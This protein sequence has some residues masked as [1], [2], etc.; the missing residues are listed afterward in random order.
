MAPTSRFEVP[1]VPFNEGGWGPCTLP[2]HLKDVPYAPYGKN[3]RIGRVADWTSSG[4]YGNNKFDKRRDQNRNNRNNDG[5]NSDQQVANSVFGFFETDKEEDFRLVD[6]SQPFKPRFGRKPQRYQS[7]RDRERERERELQLKGGP[8][9]QAAKQQQPKRKENW[10]YYHRDNNRYKYAASVDIRPEWSVLEQIQLSSLNKL[11]FKASPGKVL[12]KCGKL[13]FY[14]KAYDRVTPRNDVTLRKQ[15]PYNTANVTA[16]ED[17][18]LSKQEA[19]DGRVSIY[20]TDTVL[21]TLMCAPRSV[22]S[23]DI[24]VKKEGNKIFLDKRPENV[25][26]LVTVSETSPEPINPDKESINGQTKLSKEATVINTVFSHQMMKQGVDEKTFDLA[27]ASLNKGEG[28]DEE[29][30]NKD[31]E[32]TS[33]PNPFAQEGQTSTKGHI[34]KSWDLGDKYTVF[35]RC[36]VDGVMESRGQTVLANFR[37]VNEFDPKITGVDWR[38]KIEN[39]RGAVLATELKN[40]SNKLSK[41]TAQAVLGGVDML[42]LGYVSRVHHKDPNRHTIITTQSFKP[43][44]FGNQMNLKEENGWGILVAMMDFIA[45]DGEYLIFKDPNRPIVRVYETPTDAFSTMFS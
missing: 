5:N 43:K 20:A 4:N 21:A 12:L 11:S 13:A 3:D 17:P 19:A 30:N 18:I 14:D 6:N 37:A 8:A 40:N 16:S 2:A 31:K 41:W 36:D 7:R 1:A 39:Q 25:I 35:L 32:S 26:D 34:Y 33:C 29:N 27:G 23:W 10:H 28:S 42:K 38:Q 45:K 15:I 9:A 24:V 22:Y 44:D